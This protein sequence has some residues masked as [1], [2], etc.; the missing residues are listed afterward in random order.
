MIHLLKLIQHHH[1]QSLSLHTYLSS[2]DEQNS[3]C[4]DETIWDDEM[5][6]PLSAFGGKLKIP[7]FEKSEN[8]SHFISMFQE[9]SDVRSDVVTSYKIGITAIKLYKFHYSGIG[10][11]PLVPYF[12]AS[13]RCHVLCLLT[14]LLTWRVNVSNY[15]DVMVTRSSLVTLFIT[16]VVI[17]S[18]R[19]D[20]VIRNVI[21]HNKIILFMRVEFYFHRNCVKKPLLNINLFIYLGKGICANC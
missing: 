7:H 4:T 2:I 10:C 6:F 16:R 1:I 12:Y 13:I 21:K 17:F 20:F 5:C 18:T 3:C 9:L 11:Q 19:H 14:D 15:F 8:W